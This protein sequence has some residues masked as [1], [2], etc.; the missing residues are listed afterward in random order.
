[1]KKL[2]ESFICAFKGLLYVIRTQRNMRIHLF[3]AAGVILAGIFLGLTAVKI[4]ILCC[5]IIFV[6]IAEIVN[7]ALELSLD[8]VNN[9]K[10]NPSIKMAKDIVASAMLVASVNAVIV[11]CIIFLPHLIR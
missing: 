2:L 7:T 10:F 11:G 1:M 3:L 4:A 8:S 6:L 5:V 9:D